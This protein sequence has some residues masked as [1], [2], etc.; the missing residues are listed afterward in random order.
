M[1]NEIAGWD[2]LFQNF[3]GIFRFVAF[4]GVLSGE[5]ASDDVFIEFS[6]DRALI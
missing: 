4:Y 6:S 1:V 3:S 2:A 5:V